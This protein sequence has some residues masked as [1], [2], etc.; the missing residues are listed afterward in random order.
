[1]LRAPA[2]S[3]AVLIPETDTI[4]LREAVRSEL[5]E[6]PV[7]PQGEWRDPFYLYAF[8][9]VPLT[10]GAMERRER[11]W[12]RT[13]LAH[14]CKRHLVARIEEIIALGRMF[15]ATPLMVLIRIVSSYFNLTRGV[16]RRLAS[17]TS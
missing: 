11:V 5:P 15:L 17:E 6:R 13:S 12:I 2:W 8:L 9:D 7:H 10:G 14:R 16:A 4:L 3:K 1:M